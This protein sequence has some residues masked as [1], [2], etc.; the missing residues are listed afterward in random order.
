MSAD[1]SEKSPTRIIDLRALIPAIVYAI[2][3]VIW[4]TF[5]FDLPF[6]GHF[7]SLRANYGTMQALLIYLFIFTALIFFVFYI[8]TTFISP[9]IWKIFLVGVFCLIVFFEY[10]Y[11]NALGRF[12]GSVDLE[13]AFFITNWQQKTGAVFENFNWL[14]IFPCLIFILMS[15]W[16][17]PKEV[18][19]RKFLFIFPPVLLTL[20][21]LVAGLF[22]EPYQKIYPLISFASFPREIIEIPPVWF[23]NYDGKRETLERP[24]NI[25]D[26][27]ENN[28]IF[29]VDESV[30]SSN[31]SL[32]GYQRE[33]TP[34]LQ[35]LYQNGKIKKFNSAISGTACST[36][37]A[38]L[39]LTGLRIEDLPDINNRKSKTRPTLYQ[40]AKALN[41]KVH[42]F[43]GQMNNFWNSP[44]LDRQFVEVWK[45]RDDFV[46]AGKSAFDIDLEIAR[47]IRKIIS[48]SS[49][50]FIW[51]WKR[52]VHSPF[53]DDYPEEKAIWRPVAENP[54]FNLNSSEELTNSYDNGIKYNLDSFFK[55]LAPEFES[56]SKNILL[57]TSDHGESVS[58]KRNDSFTQEKKD[59][60]RVQV[61][62]FLMGDFNET[63]DPEFKAT[64][65]N[66][67]STLLDLMKI[68]EK[69]RKYKYD[70][71]LFDENENPSNKRYY[72]G[73]DLKLDE[74]YPFD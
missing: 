60:L 33:T 7:V 28:V 35:E 1:S 37:S 26:R 53:Y 64:H 16:R 32:Y 56:G 43:D 30:S 36:S 25:P 42:F 52:G 57:Y 54:V 14:V 9:T 22:K 69:I 3:F 61:P 17:K 4:E 72:W 5:V 39:L 10:G 18:F 8:Y 73:C 24:E 50:N 29:V 67:F 6:I 70:R 41:Y 49:G 23:F 62:L 21:F 47:H 34:F 65:S 48:T 68:P 59:R 40:Y 11:A 12:A 55:I 31:L 20:N 45:K 15:L 74:K 71:S 13:V 27:P 2:F 51:I 58:L 46:S 63:I 44:Y 19:G 38:Y 66:I